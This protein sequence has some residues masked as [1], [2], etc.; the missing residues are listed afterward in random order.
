MFSSTINNRF[1]ASWIEVYRTEWNSKLGRKSTPGWHS[2]QVG[3]EARERESRNQHF[4]GSKNS[5]LWNLVLFSFATCILL[6]HDFQKAEAR[7]IT[8]TQCWK[9]RSAPRSFRWRYR[10]G[11]TEIF[12][13]LRLFIEIYDKFIKSFKILKDFMRIGLLTQFDGPQK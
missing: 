8:T 7:K 6:W 12:D 5:K 9:C 2:I 11:G 1:S 4:V 13:F 3:M 10:H